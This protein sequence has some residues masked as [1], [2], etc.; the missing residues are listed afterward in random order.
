ML[1]WIGLLGSSGFE[2]T[3]GIMSR[4]RMANTNILL[5]CGGTS[6]PINNPEPVEQNE[7]WSESRKNLR[8][9][10]DGKLKLP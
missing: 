4:P 9:T 10:R 1:G 7:T 5:N 6:I 3:S 8:G 2:R